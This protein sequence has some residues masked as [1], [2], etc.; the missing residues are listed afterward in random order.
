MSER[1]VGVLRAWGKA[2]KVNRSTSYFKDKK[3]KPGR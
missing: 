3:Q 1:T 2:H